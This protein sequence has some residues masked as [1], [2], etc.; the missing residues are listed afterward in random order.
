MTVEKVRAKFWVK[1]VKQNHLGGSGSSDFH[2]DVELSPCYGTYPGGDAE[3]NK[4]FSKWTPSGE[5]KLSITNPAAID[6]FD[7]GK[8]YYIDF[9]PAP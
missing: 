2:A 6:F 7:L 4:S 8:A 1:S 9:T 3:E 5:I